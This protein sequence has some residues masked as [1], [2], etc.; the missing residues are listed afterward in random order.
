LYYYTVAKKHCV[1]VILFEVGMLARAE[2]NNSRNRSSMTTSPSMASSD[3]SPCSEVPFYWP[4]I[5]P[6]PSFHSV[7]AK[8]RESKKKKATVETFPKIRV[9][10]SSRHDNNTTMAPLPAVKKVLHRRPRWRRFLQTVALWLLVCGFGISTVLLHNRGM[11]VVVSFPPSGQNV[12]QDATAPDDLSFAAPLLQPRRAVVVTAPAAAA[13]ASTSETVA[14]KS[15]QEELPDRVDGGNPS[16]HTTHPAVSSTSPRTNR[17]FPDRCLPHNSERWIRGEKETTLLGGKL[18]PEEIEV[19]MEG[20]LHFD[21]LHSL[22][23][24]TICHDQ[25]PL[26]QVQTNHTVEPAPSLS[27]WQRTEDW[28]QRFFYLAMHWKFHKPALPEYKARKQCQQDATLR[29]EMESFLQQHKIGD[30]DFECP[31]AKFIVSPIGNIGFGALINTQV[32]MTI[33]IAL[34]TG[35]IPVFTAH[36]LYRW[37]RTDMDPWLLAPR[38][39]D[40]RNLQCYYMPMTPCALLVEDVRNA[41]RYGSDGKEQRWLK[42]HMNV[43]QDMSDHRIV[44]IN[45]GLQTKPSETEDI[46][47]IAADI[48]G[49]LMEEWKKQQQQ[50]QQQQLQA[51]AK[52]WSDDDWKAMELAKQWMVDKTRED[53]SGLMRQMFVY[54]F[55]FNPHYKKV[56]RERMSALVPP[57]MHPAET[58]GIAIRGSDKCNKESTCLPFPRYMEL[59]SDV[60]Y[61]TLGIK[62]HEP[63]PRLIMTTEDPN[64]FN[65][66]LSF[67]QN[68]S[69]PFQFLVNDQDNMQGSGFPRDFRNQGENTIVS[70][71][72][73]L[74]LHLSAGRVYLNCC[75]NFH[76]VIGTL[77]GAQ[78]GAV[79][80]GS[81]FVNNHMSTQNIAT[82]TT[83][84]VGF[85]LNNAK[86]VPQRYRICCGWY[87]NK[88]AACNEIWT[89]HLQNRQDIADKLK[90][91]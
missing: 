19:I 6:P 61:P 73:A 2:L 1:S 27:F 80:H 32:S 44:A 69:F 35:R 12:S 25:S 87:S 3:D 88:D 45:S 29:P 70:S 68:A 34:R 55:R 58:V 53:P 37:Q 36:S 17:T 43:P 90:K 23:Q 65:E 30:L 84:P 63:R 57:S 38:L 13:A 9:K 78:C 26:K 40:P 10:P 64:V 21:K 7:V 49:E 11:M 51:H 83:P 42:N 54:F 52:L 81:T 79:R 46:R 85:C 39:C 22:F 5:V 77:L 91:K 16:S 47:A 75:S 82:Q 86:V 59:V 20:P 60:V 66:S 71:M 62:P 89:E 31:D 33:L 14:V 18:S 72:T 76:A 67:Q 15:Q 4:C 50:Q 24:E 56:L 48:V 8:E 41:T 74:Q 28:Y